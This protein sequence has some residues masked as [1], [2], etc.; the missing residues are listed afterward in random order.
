[1]KVSGL[2]AVPALGTLSASN[3]N[4]ALQT[5]TM[6][7]ILILWDQLLKAG[8][9]PA[10]DPAHAWSRDL[11]N[12]YVVPYFQGMQTRQQQVIDTYKVPIAETIS[13]PDLRVM[14]DPVAAERMTSADPTIR[15]AQEEVDA[16]QAEIRADNLAQIQE[17]HVQTVG[18]MVLQPTSPIKV[19]IL[20]GL[21]FLLSLLF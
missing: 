17:N 14:F 10:N 11:L 20:A 2:G 9:V 19:P 5:M 15:G 12:N 18:P 6:D 4:A 21:G 1:M 13:A 7:E 3:I 8:E 16:Q